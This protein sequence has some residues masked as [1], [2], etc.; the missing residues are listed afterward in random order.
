MKTLWIKFRVEVSH[1]QYA[2]FNDTG[3]AEIEIEIPASAFPSLDTGNLLH[4]LL[5]VA[6][7]R[8]SE[9]DTDEN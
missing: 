7:E 6:L 8:L 2:I 4:T 1:E 5:P 9:K 3:G